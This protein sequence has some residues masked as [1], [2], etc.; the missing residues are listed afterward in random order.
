MFSIDTHVCGRQVLCAVHMVHTPQLS[1]WE[2]AESSRAVDVPSVE[3]RQYQIDACD[4]IQESLSRVRSTLLVMAT[5]TG[6]TTV[7]GET[8]RRFGGVRTLVLAHRDELIRQIDRRIKSQTGLTTSVEKASEYCNKTSNVVVASVPTLSSNRP[9]PNSAPIGMND[10][11]EPMFAPRYHRLERFSADSFGLIVIDEAHHAVGDS[12]RRILD[13]FKGALV[14]GVT[15]TP[16]RSDKLAMGTVFGDVAYKYEINDAINDGWLCRV[17][18]MRVQ[19]DAVRLDSVKTTAGDLN[20]GQLDDVM[21]TEQALHQVARPT[22]E[23]SGSRRTLVFTTS[24]G[25][26]ERL[27][28]IFCR[29]RSGCA[30]FVTGKTPP[31]ERKQILADHQSGKYQFLVNVGVLTEG[32]D[33]PAV[34]CVAIGRPTKSRAL[35]AQMA[36]RGTRTSP[37][38]ADLLLLDFVGNSGRHTLIGAV[39]VLAGREPDEVAERARAIIARAQLPMDTAEA[40]AQAKEE[41]RL[42]R[43]TE[44]GLRRAATADFKYRSTKLDPFEIFGIPDK[45]SASKFGDEPATFKQL[46]YLQK[47]RIPIAPGLSKRVAGTLITEQVRRRNEGLCTYKQAEILLKHGYDTKDMSFALAGA[48]MDRLSKNC[49]KSLSQSQESDAIEA[50]YR[51]QSQR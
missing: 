31:T 22:I 41:L 20:Q 32:Y 37:G 44:A 24:V 15:A 7:I 45:R 50:S 12:Y 26:A 47:C 11:G 4:R 33:D 19:C 46:G 29:Y 2:A 48:L 43:L 34:S 3:L 18:A 42:K 27:A 13:H 21:S 36:G 6:K 49:W 10:L 40:I 17:S 1:M 16:D 23:L 25:N 5:G 35:Y 14:L 39:D 28:E 51:P 8:I 9:N 30:R 38:K